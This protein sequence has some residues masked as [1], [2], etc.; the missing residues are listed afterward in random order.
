MLA[1]VLAALRARVTASAGHFFILLLLTTLATGCNRTIQAQFNR[2]PSGGLLSSN[3]ACL[4]DYDADGFWYV[5]FLRQDLLGLREHRHA[6]GH[7]LMLTRSG[8]LVFYSRCSGRGESIDIDGKFF[9]IKQGQVFLVTVQQD[10]TQIIQL[11]A[12]AKRF[13]GNDPAA[14]A[15]ALAALLS[16]PTVQAFLSGDARLRI[17]KDAQSQKPQNVK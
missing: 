13:D 17:A 9:S 8:D 12:Q 3:E 4:Y 2:D 7:H 6:A 10:N 15:N 16:E 1:R 11:P 14:R 5:I